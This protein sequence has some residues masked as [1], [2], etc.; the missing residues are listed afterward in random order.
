VDEEQLRLVSAAKKGDKDAFT[1]L[2]RD[3]KDYV[4]RISYGILTNHAE[5]EDV[6]QEVFVKAYLQLSSIREA[7]SFPSWLAT[8]ATRRAIDVY[9]RGQ[10]LPLVSIEPDLLGGQADEIERAEKRMTVHDM[11]REL[12]PIHRAV[13]VLRELEGYEYEEIANVLDIP[14]GTVRSRLSTARTQ[15]RRWA[16]LSGEV[17]NDEQ[18]R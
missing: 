17:S 4:Y 12:N 9:K 7:R 3:Y 6:T 2:V 13:L 11:L 10:R 18:P 15:L 5:A 16:K 8:I 14:I 1:A